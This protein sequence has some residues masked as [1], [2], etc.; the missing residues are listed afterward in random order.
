MSKA[1]SAIDL[2][3]ALNNNQSAVINIRRKV[4]SNHPVYDVLKP[5][6]SDLVTLPTGSGVIIG[7]NEQDNSYLVATNYHVLADIG[8]E[9]RDGIADYGI[10]Y[11]QALKP[12][13]IEFID[14]VINPKTLFKPIDSDLDLRFFSITPQIAQGQAN[15]HVMRMKDLPLDPNSIADVAIA[16]YQGYT[17]G[18]NA[19]GSQTIA[20][21]TGGSIHHDD[22]FIWSDENEQQ[23]NL[24][25]RG[26]AFV[27]Q[28]NK[29]ISNTIYTPVNQVVDGMSGGPVFDKDGYL[30]G[31]NGVAS[32]P[33][34]AGFASQ[35]DIS[36]FISARTIYQNIPASLKEQFNISPLLDFSSDADPFIAVEYG[37]VA[38]FHATIDALDEDDIV[39]DIP[40]YIPFNSPAVEI[41]EAGEIASPQQLITLVG[42]VSAFFDDSDADANYLNQVA[43]LMGIEDNEPIF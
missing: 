18:F 14:G 16:D 12:Y 36:G 30:L 27:I 5:D 9:V 8:A 7:Y 43:T 24:S 15:Y 1:L 31:I 34:N 29:P 6:N 39:A 4:N 17:I 41:V 28:D 26:Y 35:Y 23:G 2:A 40:A 42:E 33:P 21:I 32:T 20:S 3:N 22:K 13:Q 38:D 19:N 11:D 37:R 25:N 10:A